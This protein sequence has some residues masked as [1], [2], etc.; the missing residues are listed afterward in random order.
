MLDKHAVRIRQT[1][2]SDRQY[3]VL[4]PGGAETL[5]H[6]RATVEEVALMGGLGDLAILDVDMVNCFGSLEWG[7]VKASYARQLPEFLAWE[8]WATA[9]A[10]GVKL[11]AGSVH[12]VDRGAGQGEADAPPLKRH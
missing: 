2:R 1:M 10:A 7:A 11:P 5:Y 6:V 12:M 3:G 4:C 8:N 9:V